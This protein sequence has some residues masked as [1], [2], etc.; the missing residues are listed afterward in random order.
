ML[1]PSVYAQAGRHD[2]SDID[3]EDTADSEPPRSARRKYNTPR[4]R[5]S[6]NA[7]A[8]SEPTFPLSHRHTTPRGEPTGSPT[9]PS[10]L[11]PD[12][13]SSPTRLFPPLSHRDA[14]PRDAP[15]DTPT[16]LPSCRV[17]FTP[18]PPNKPPNR[19]APILITPPDSPESAS[20]EASDVSLSDCSSSEEESSSMITSCSDA[21]SSVMLSA[22]CP[23]S[24]FS[25]N[26]TVYKVQRPPRPSP[27]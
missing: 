18:P 6:T 23:E 22:R 4:L 16:S 14:T 13:H 12:K 9:H 15:M 21:A 5:W 1:S 3:L 24:I 2:L 20:D 17:E 8:D 7:A 19:Y 10:E 25:F 27:P 26:Q 11:T